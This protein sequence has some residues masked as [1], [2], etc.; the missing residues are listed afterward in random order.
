MRC[1][2]TLRPGE[3]PRPFAVLDRVARDL[4]AALVPVPA[5]VLLF[6]TEHG[7][8]VAR[9][10]AML[11]VHEAEAGLADGSVRIVPVLGSARA[12]LRAASFADA[13]PRLAALALDAT[14]LADQG[15]GEAERVQARA[16]AALAAAAADV[17]LIVLARGP[18]G[19]VRAA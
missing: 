1:T 10:G 12:V 11:A 16:M 3:E 9:L 14:A 8:E 19:S 18:A 17:P 2:L 15:L 7:C 5:G 13:G 4:A 6:G